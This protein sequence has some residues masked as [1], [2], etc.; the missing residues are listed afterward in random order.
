MKLFLALLLPAAI[1][2]AILPDAIGEHQRTATSRP[3]IAD[4]TVWNEYGLKASETAAYGDFSVTVWQ[5]QDTTGSLAAFQW[6]RPA[7]ATAAG[8]L[9]AETKTGLLLVHGN[10]LLSF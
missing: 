1:S 6:Q 2:A 3:A 5:L 10:Y 4:Q 8:P 9:A 7:G